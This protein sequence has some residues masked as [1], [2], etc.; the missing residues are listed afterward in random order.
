MDSK[1]YKIDDFYN[2]KLPTENEIKS[3]W[4][5]NKKPLVSV[6]CLTYN[7]EK[8]INDAIK[9]FLIQATTFP[10][11]VII[12]D[13]A[14]K[15]NTPTILKKYA[16]EYP[17]IIK[18]ILQQENKYSLCPNSVLKIATEEATSEYLA[19]CEG[20]DFW[21]SKDK[22]QIQINKLIE[23]NECDI[24][25]H[26]SLLINQI[27]GNTQ[28]IN[29]FDKKIID[30]KTSISSGASLMP[31]ASIVVRKKII[32]NLPPWFFQAPV[33]DY[34][35]QVLGSINSAVY[36][37]KIMSVYRANA[38]NSWSN[39]NN[40]NSK[41]FII[42]SKKMLI[43]IK[44]LECYLK[45]LSIKTD[46]ISQ[47]R[48]NLLIQHLHLSI[49]SKSLSGMYHLMKNMDFKSIPYFIKKLSSKTVKNLSQLM[50]K[51]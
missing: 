12:H 9:G 28:A 49:R 40:F 26:N 20:D 30:L 34:F 16:E 22:L 15:D 45:N 50:K 39:N 8:Y 4:I 17:N 11:E 3:T 36:I 31:T 33:G 43:S 7:Q 5:D 46:G 13:D 10:F 19:I 44:H 24:C 21:I 41:K 6:I 25:F 18:I 48:A 37:N 14:S 51:S 38:L 42:N 47:M 23:H 1:K 2:T 29:N 27:D 32:D 35:I